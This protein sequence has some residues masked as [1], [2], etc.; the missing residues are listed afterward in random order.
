M[1][2]GLKWF[3]LFFLI[4]FLGIA[5]NTFHSTGTIE[6]GGEISF[7]SQ[8]SSGNNGS[9]STFKSSLYIGVM[10]VK[11][12][13]LGFRPGFSIESYSGSSLKS[14][15]LYLN[16]NYNFVTTTNVYPYLGLIVGYNSIG[17]IDDSYSGV[18]VGAEGGLK[19]LLGPS[20]LLLVKL[21]Y[22][23][24]TYN[25]VETNFF[26]KEDLSINTISIGVGFRFFF[27]RIMKV[28]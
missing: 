2:Q 4:P 16:P 6:S 17:Y 7:A 20:S 22:L 1:K 5:Q 8:S 13:E 10:V 9:V 27:P 26:T 19:C 18:T 24:Q 3:I 12:F 23:A 14:I 21:E 15:D 11:G 28:K 25:D